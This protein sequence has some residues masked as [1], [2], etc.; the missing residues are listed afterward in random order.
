MT[1]RLE[2]VEPDRKIVI[3]CDDKDCTLTQNNEQIAEQGGLHTMGWQTKFNDITRRLEHRCPE[4]KEQ[5]S[6]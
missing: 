6:E 5:A 1:S 4:H 2:G 3:N